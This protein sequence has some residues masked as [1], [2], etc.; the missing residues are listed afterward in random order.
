M[1]FFVR[2]A[3]I[4][5]AALTPFILMICFG[6]QNSLSQYWATKGQPL[7]ITANIVTSYFFFTIKEWRSP[8]YILVLLTAFSVELFPLIHNILAISFFVAAT[9]SLYQVKRFKWYLISFILCLPLLSYSIL[10]A[11]IGGILVLSAYHAHVLIYKQILTKS[12]G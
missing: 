5:T 10:H 7:F 3:A 1:G 4:L 9:Y 11:E 2:L 6:Q 12:N 8:S